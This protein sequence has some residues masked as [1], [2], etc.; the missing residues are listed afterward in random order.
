MAVRHA[1]PSHLPP[2]YTSSA[3]DTPCYTPSPPPPP[4][5]TSEE[6]RPPPRYRTL[7]PSALNTAYDPD[8]PILRREDWI[9]ETV[10]YVGAQLETDELEIVFNHLAGNKCVRFLYLG[11]NNGFLTDNV[12]PYLVRALRLNTTLTSLRL[13]RC[14]L[15]APTAGMLGVALRS[16]HT[17]T[18]INLRDNA[19]SAEG[20]QLFFQSL[21]S[22]PS[23]LTELD[24]SANTLTDEGAMLIAVQAPVLLPRLESLTLDF[25]TLT[26][27]CIPHLARLLSTTHTTISQLSL[28][29]NRVSA[30]GAD[31]LNTAIRESK[32]RV[33]R[34][35]LFVN[36]IR[37]RTSA[38]SCW[39]RI[40]WKEKHRGG[41]GWK[42][43][44][45]PAYV[46]KT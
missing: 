33:T 10:A 38:L 13:D 14:S 39:P 4:P 7:Y 36:G 35:A 11:G 45:K 20:I 18:S 5:P 6:Q 46:R 40:V 34:V 24:L 44:G 27:A 22:T 19:I 29:E 23:S 43:V 1:L 15:G 21:G 26:D 37:T 16:N 31:L 9:G 32:G 12:I 25:N 28:S 17:L 30:H 41:G 2:T 3:N 42:A 8:E